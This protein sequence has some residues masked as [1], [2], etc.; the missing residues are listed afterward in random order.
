MDK[1]GDIQKVLL[2]ETV[3]E[4][5]RDH[6]GNIYMLSSDQSE[7]ITYLVLAGRSSEIV[8]SLAN[9]CEVSWPLR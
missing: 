9:D 5:P 4:E 3:G 6:R 7:E 1:F 8:M 2:G